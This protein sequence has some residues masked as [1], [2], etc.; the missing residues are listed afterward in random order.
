LSPL[1]ISGIAFACILG[2]TLLGM[3]VRR[4]LPAHHLDGESKDAVKLGLALIGTLTALVLGLLVASAKGTYDTQNSTVKELSAKIILLDRA[5][6][7][8]GPET[9]E[10]RELLRRVV[11][12]LRERLWP[13][14]SARSGDLSLGEARTEMEQFYGKLAN[15]SPQNDDAKRALKARAMD[16]TADVAATRLRLYAQR[17]SSIPNTLLVVLVVWLTVLYAGYGMLAPRNPTVLAVLVVCVLSVAGALFLIL[18]LGRPFEGVLRISSGP[19]R[20]ALEQI[21]K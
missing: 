6:A 5:L 17:D 13:E 12:L 14:D 19:V 4:W 20:D 1:T 11:E 16:L 3:L 18:E 8:Y 2:G 9:K 15:L 10:A 21:G 7:L